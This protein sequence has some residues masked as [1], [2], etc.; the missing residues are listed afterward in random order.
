VQNINF[1]GEQAEADSFLDQLT[2]ISQDLVDTDTVMQAVLSGMDNSDA[3]I[4]DLRFNGGGY[5]NVSLKI[6]SYF[7]NTEQT[8]GTK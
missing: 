7:S 3:L 4:I 6:A 1:A 8:I 2:L 5:D